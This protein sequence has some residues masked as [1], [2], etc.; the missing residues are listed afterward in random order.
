MLV[1]GGSAIVAWGSPRTVATMLTIALACVFGLGLLVFLAN[2]A[3]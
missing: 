1:G 2:L 3:V